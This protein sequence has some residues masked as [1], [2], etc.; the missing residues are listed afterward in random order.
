MCVLLMVLFVLSDVPEAFPAVWAATVSAC[1]DLKAAASPAFGSKRPDVAW[2][3]STLLSWWQEQQQQQQQG[4]LPAAADLLSPVI[5]AA[6]KL[7]QQA[8]SA[9]PDGVVGFEGTGSA[10][11]HG[12][13]DDFNFFNSLSFVDV[14]IEDEEYAEA[15]SKGFQT[16]SDPT[17][18]VRSVLKADMLRSMACKFKAISSFFSSAEKQQGDGAPVML[19]QDAGKQLL[20]AVCSVLAGTA[21]S[22]SSNTH[23]PL[24]TVQELLL[25][26]G[27]HPQVAQQLQELPSALCAVVQSAAAHGD[28]S[29]HRLVVGAAAD[30]QGE[31]SHRLQLE[32]GDVMALHWAAVAGVLKHLPSS[33]DSNIHLLRLWR[34]ALSSSSAIFAAATAGDGFLKNNSPQLQHWMQAAA[35]AVVSVMAADGQLSTQLLADPLPVGVL[36]QLMLSAPAATKQQGGMQET[37][38]ANQAAVLLL[39]HAVQHDL[40]KDLVLSTDTAVDRSTAGASRLCR[41]VSC[42]CAAGTAAAATCDWCATGQ[43]AAAL[44]AAAAAAKH[45]NIRVMGAAACLADTAGEGGTAHSMGGSGLGPCTGGL[46]QQRSGQRVLAAVPAG[47]AEASAGRRGICPA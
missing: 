27:Q 23:V 13:T 29:T 37:A 38:G 3:T 34:E 4:S 14:S 12:R 46:Q 10:E 43:A 6:G 45:S 32:A 17:P 40:L 24:A 2:L 11:Q 21:H 44:C 16:K 30:S 19:P 39:G 8:Q 28:L 7:L 18:K 31:A 20:H 25:V 47:T 36:Q 1:T 42:A 33:R 15:A 22:G 35:A 5:A 41:Y 9:A 26:M